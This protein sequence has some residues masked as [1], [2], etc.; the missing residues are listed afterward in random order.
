M[1]PKVIVGIL[2][3]NNEDFIEET[4]WS[5]INQT[6]NNLEIVVHDDCSTDKSLEVVAEVQK[7]C[8]R[9]INVLL[10]EKN[11]GI[12]RSLNRIIESFS[13][14]Y[15]CFVGSDDRYLPDF[16]EKRV[17]LM[18]SI[19]NSFEICYS[20]SYFISEK[21]ENVGVEK[22]PGTPSG[23]IFEYIMSQKSQ[24]LCKPL[25]LFYRKSVFLKVGLF[26]DDLLFEDL[27]F[28]LR[29]ARY[30]KFYFYDSF[31]SEYRMRSK[32]SSLG[33]KV[34]SPQGV[35]SHIK[36]V[37]KHLGMSP[38]MNRQINERKLY[39]LYRGANNKNDERFLFF[40]LFKEC[41]FII[42][43]LKWSICFVLIASLCLKIGKNPLHQRAMFKIAKYVLR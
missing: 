6:Y 35:L 28:V 38:K 41:S 16:V 26:D 21:G 7:K 13:G 25:S 14:D 34:F 17:L 33:S 32:N 18:E 24:S 30:C 23:Y 36:L 42:S 11:L 20:L 22:R 37:N 40:L 27:D 10:A 3:Y 1:N 9:R 4:L 43:P 15:F 2:S 8:N 5:V 39:Y 19:P 12:C 31:D 29:A